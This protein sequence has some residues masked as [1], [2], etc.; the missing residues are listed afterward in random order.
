MKKNLSIAAALAAFALS[1]C[2]GDSNSSSNEDYK[3]VNSVE[4]LVECN[5]ETLGEL[6]YVEETDSVYECTSDGW[7]ATVSSS[8]ADSSIKSS[9]SQKANDSTA[10]KIVEVNSVTLTG[11]A[12]K[13]PFEKGSAVTVY[14]LDSLL[15]KTKTKFTGKVAGDSGAYSVE[16][17]DLPSQFALVEVNGN[18]ISE[19]T[20]KK[21]TGSKTK[22][23][24]I[25]D[26]SEGNTVKAN[27]NIF[28]E[29]EFARVKY[30]VVNEKLSIPAAK[31]RATNELLDLFGSENGESS[32]SATDLSLMDTSAA[33]T[34]LLTTSILLQGD[35]SPA[36]F[37]GRLDEISEIFAATGKLD[38]AKIRA[39]LADWAYDTDNSDNFEEIYNNVKSMNLTSKVP[40]FATILTNFW[41]NEYGLEA[42]TEK[43]EG[44]LKNIQNKESENSDTQYLC[45][46]KRWTKASETESAFGLCTEKINGEFKS[47]EEIGDYICEWDGEKGEWREATKDESDLYWL[48]NCTDKKQDTII[49]TGK[50]IEGVGRGNIPDDNSKGKYYRCNNKG[51]E[52]SDK[53]HFTYGA[54]CK[55]SYSARFSAKELA[56]EDGIMDFRRNNALINR[57]FENTSDWTKEEQDAYISL[58]IIDR[59]TISSAIC[60]ND[61]WTKITMEDFN[62]RKVCADSI[63]GR[64]LFGKDVQGKIYYSETT[65]YICEKQGDSYRWKKELVDMR[66]SSIYRT[67]TIGQQ[68]WMAE[69]LNYRF[70]ETTD[71]G[72]AADTSSFCLND[73]IHYCKDY[74]RIYYWSTAMDSIR[75]YDRLNVGCGYGTDINACLSSMGDPSFKDIC[76]NGYHLP[77]TTE[78]NILIKN[79]GGRTDG[80]SKLKA[81]ENWAGTNEFGFSVEP[82]GYRYKANNGKVSFYTG[83]SYFWTS[84]HV[85]SSTKIVENHAIIFYSD[86]PISIEAL[87]LDNYTASVR[88]I[89][90]D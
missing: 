27:V 11:F 55:S 86:F 69:N 58:F 5:N 49:W 76:P 77:D 59:D 6:F 52:E 79:A 33:G 87:S 50:F 10:T 41:I 46:E 73:N 53:I 16:K 1:A 67:V 31:K 89:K 28:T 8:S 48:G 84:T 64:R 56:S 2:G 37:A 85:T 18:Y 19:I 7:L 83:I 88:C 42:C 51:W 43:L 20:G 23:N 4:D 13:G 66:D 81:P 90:N 70:V 15:E 22:L 44:T 34:T 80:A 12:Q 38:S 82:A 14:G 62:A 17:I 74:G 30:L 75:N 71:N 72:T 40:D 60:K 32:L 47:S 26:L 24:A 3:E 39:E 78:W 29:L 54:T 25:V 21:T 35:L 61:N 9:S 45:T 36:K 63:V 57:F 65:G 68:T